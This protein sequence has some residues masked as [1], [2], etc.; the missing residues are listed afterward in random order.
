[1]GSTPSPPP[2]P[3]P[4]ATAA[5]QT[6][7]NVTTA[8]ANN[9]MSKVPQ[10]DQYGNTTTY[11]V[12]GSTPLT[13]PMSGATY[14]LPNYSET[15]SM[16]P[17]NQAIYSAQ[18]GAEKQLANAAGTLGGQINNQIQTPLNLSQY[19]TTA[20]AP[21]AA[22]INSYANNSWE[23]PFNTSWNIQQQQLDQK[24]ADQGIN[25]G[26]NAYNQAEFGFTQNQ[27]QAMDSYA[28]GM[29]GTAT[30]AALGSYNSELAKNAQNAQLAQS[31]YTLPLNE[32]SSL[33][34]SSQVAS[35]Q[36]QNIQT[37]T[38]PTTD[39]ATIAQNTYQDQLAGYQ[40]QQQNNAAM[41]G[42]LFGLGGSLIMGGG[43]LM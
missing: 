25:P 42:G 43:L 30:Q 4:Q 21:T 38:I 23:T 41:Y 34:G 15:T 7:E 12:T 8:V 17:A 33:L 32:M 1:M 3:S 27:Q 40:I 22:D 26:S 2:V 11:N 19:Q 18:Q 5:A 16:S 9:E 29:Y 28:S 20:N 39:Y 35:P 13:D 10:T 36:F 24:L 37:P 14:Q 31:Q 6:S